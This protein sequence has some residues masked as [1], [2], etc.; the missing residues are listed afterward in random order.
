[1][2][3]YGSFRPLFIFIFYTTVEYTLIVVLTC[4]INFVVVIIVVVVVFV[5]VVVV[6]VV[7]QLSGNSWGL[8]E[9]IQ[10]RII[11]L[12]VVITIPLCSVGGGVREVAL[13]AVSPFV[14]IG[15]EEEKDQDPEGPGRRRE[16]RGRSPL[17]GDDPRGRS[18]SSLWDWS[19]TRRGD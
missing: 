9:Q 4:I 7:N 19:G 14:V 1:M 15:E 13:G 17:R 16:R 18:S 3:L 8:T 11:E 5:V 6:V 2:Y 12:M 10:R